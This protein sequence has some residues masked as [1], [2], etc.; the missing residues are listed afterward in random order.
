MWTVL[1]HLLIFLNLWNTQQLRKQRSIKLV[2]TGEKLE[3]LFHSKVNPGS[4]F[5]T[6]PMRGLLTIPASNA[7]STLFTKSFLYNISSHDNEV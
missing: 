5:L 6:K 2:D 7:D 1:Y 3:N 4:Q